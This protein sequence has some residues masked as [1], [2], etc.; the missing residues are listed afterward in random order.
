MGSSGGEAI[1][2]S[3]PTPATVASRAPSNGTEAFMRPLLRRLA[4]RFMELDRIPVRVLDL[5]LLPARP[6]LDLVPEAAVALLQGGHDG[7]EVVHV[8]HDPVPA[9]GL[10]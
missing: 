1:L 7:V 10:L 5:D 6:D 9:P 8:Q 2:T 4:G 3:A